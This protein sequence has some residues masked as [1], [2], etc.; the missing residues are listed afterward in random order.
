MLSKMGLLM[1][2]YLS[3]NPI[4]LAVSG[5]AGRSQ[6]RDFMKSWVKATDRVPKGR[7]SYKPNKEEK[8]LEN[9]IK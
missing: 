6:W 5:F 7:L 8:L 4:Y 2:R 1:R 9:G 3:Y